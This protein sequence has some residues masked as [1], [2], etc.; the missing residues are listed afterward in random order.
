MSAKSA[1]R[2]LSTGLLSNHD[3]DIHSH[4]LSPLSRRDSHFAIEMQD[5]KSP[6]KGESPYAFNDENQNYDTSSFTEENNDKINK[7][8]TPFQEDAVSNNSPAQTVK[9]SPNG[10]D[11]SVKSRTGKQ[12]PEHLVTP[13]RDKENTFQSDALSSSP[14]VTLPSSAGSGK[15]TDLDLPRS[16]ASSS[17]SG[18]KSGN[19]AFNDSDYYCVDHMKLCSSQVGFCELIY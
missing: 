1:N 14:S 18:G 3:A 15:L 2:T 10:R 5:I 16:S 9:V 12:L 4:S 8:I 19:E 13:S 11:S 7:R 6:Q 17:R